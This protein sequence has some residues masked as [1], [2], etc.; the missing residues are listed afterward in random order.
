MTKIKVLVATAEPEKATPIKPERFKKYIDF[1]IKNDGYA[2]SFS[3]HWLFASSK[4]EFFKAIESFKPDILHLYG[5]GDQLSEFYFE[6]ADGKQEP[7]SP[8]NFFKKY[9]VSLRT[10]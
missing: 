10:R 4:E 8:N 3:F 1:N 9:Q 5:H 7:I 6:K 2:D